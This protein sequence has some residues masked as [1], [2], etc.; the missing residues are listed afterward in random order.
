MVKKLLP[1]ITFLVAVLGAGY[2]GYRVGLSQDQCDPRCS[3]TLS[4]SGDPVVVAVVPGPAEQCAPC[5]VWIDSKVFT[6]G[7][8]EVSE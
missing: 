3:V 1:L 6:P 4:G 5:P 7:L 8:R 2:V